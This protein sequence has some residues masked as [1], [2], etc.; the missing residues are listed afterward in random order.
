[1][2][3][4][5]EEGRPR[6]F[7]RKKYF[8]VRVEKNTGS[9]RREMAAVNAS[10]VKSITRECDLSAA[11]SWVTRYSEIGIVRRRSNHEGKFINLE[12]E[13]LAELYICRRDILVLEKLIIT[14]LPIVQIV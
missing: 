13:V 8:S 6:N 9:A 12:K 3:L 11:I 5:Y 10:S 14:R 7:F 4:L 1:M 2:R